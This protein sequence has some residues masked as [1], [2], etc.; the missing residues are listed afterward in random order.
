M[1]RPRQKP[2]GVQ[3]LFP[4]VLL[5]RVFSILSRTIRA[6][7]LVFR[8]SLATNLS[9]PAACFVGDP[10]LGGI[11][12]MLCQKSSR[13]VTVLASPV[14]LFPTPKKRDRKMI[15]HHAPPKLTALAAALY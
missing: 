13:T 3:F 11:P 1:D 12:Q 5:A 10:D 4:Q 7:G 9:L 15:H 8:H 14:A 2:L 6:L